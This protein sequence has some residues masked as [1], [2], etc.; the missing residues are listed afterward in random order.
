MYGIFTYSWVI[1][2]V[3]VGKCSIHGASGANYWQVENGI[4]SSYIPKIRYLKKG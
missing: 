3:N 1:F 2:G 4:L